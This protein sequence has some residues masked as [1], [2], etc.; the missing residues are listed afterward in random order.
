M[1]T[2]VK[3]PNGSYKARK[4]IP[5]DVQACYRERY[6]AGHEA[7]LSIPAGT[8]PA[9]AQRLFGVWLSETEARFEAI[10]AE[11]DGRGLTLSPQQAAALA[12]EWYGWFTARRADTPLEVLERVQDDV[13][14][15]LRSSVNEAVAARSNPDDIWRHDPAAREA[16]RPIL[17]D[18]GE[19]AQFL[20]AKRV[21]LTPPSRDALLDEL[22]R[23][24]AAAIKLFVRRAEG[25]SWEDT[26]SARFPKFEAPDS[27]LTPWAMFEQWVTARGPA[28]STMESWRTVFRALQASFEGRSA[29][30]ITP[31]EAQAWI[32]GRVSARRSAKTVKDTWI[33]ATR[34]V[35]TSAFDDKLLPFNAFA[36]VKIKVP[37][38]KRL[39]EKT[40]KLDEIRLILRAASAIDAERHPDDPAK[41]WLPWLCGYT[42]ARPGEIAQLRKRDVLNIEGIFALDLTPD[43]GT[44]KTSEARLVPIHEHLIEQ[45]FL[46]FVSERPDGPLFYR[47]A[48]DRPPVTPTKQPKS[49]A[50]QLRQRIAAWV[51]DIGVD[52]KGVS[53]NHGWRHTFKQIAERHGISERMHDHITG[54]SPATTGRTYG[55]PSLQDVADAMKKFPRYYV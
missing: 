12:G 7:K 42:G 53:P 1:P 16:V 24:L 2:P 54:H 15:A 13:S 29:A 51:R 19:V 36:D 23:D 5:N 4:R 52:A 17:H 44:I 40:F 37:K 35:F 43:A 47:S 21:V 45:G 46:Q 10:R 48:T 38:Q 14:S 11:R 3:Q 28:Q 9:E 55:A 26:H 20:A 22:Y 8:K 31:E 25:G 32:T 30:S 49:K 50:A 27:G 6:G 34:S 41:R 39:R 33:S 18:F